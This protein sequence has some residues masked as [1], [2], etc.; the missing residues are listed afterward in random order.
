M[1]FPLVSWGQ[2]EKI[3]FKIIKGLPVIECYANKKPAYL[4]L[5]TGA[6]ISLIDKKAAKNWDFNTYEVKDD[7][8]YQTIGG[9]GGQQVPHRLQDIVIE[10]S[11]ENLT[12]LFEYSID[13]SNVRKLNG[14][15]GIIGTDFFKDGW[16]IDF[17]RMELIK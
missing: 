15:V 14:V 7:P 16:V 11:G 17:E 4:L 5:D 8:K 10:V 12:G 13:L 3:P 1:L 6:S 9:I 2:E